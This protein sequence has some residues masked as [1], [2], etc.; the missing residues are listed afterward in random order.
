MVWSD[1]NAWDYN[2]GSRF[3]ADGE[4]YLYLIGR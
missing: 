4:V 3:P 2:V 1:L